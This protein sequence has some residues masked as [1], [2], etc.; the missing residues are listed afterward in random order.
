MSGAVAV[1]FAQSVR[2]EGRLYGGME[3]PVADEAVGASGPDRVLAGATAGVVR[4]GGSG[5]WT[6]WVKAWGMMVTG[7]AHSR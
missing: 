1:D 6:L 2:E 7:D 5:L 4:G 3:R